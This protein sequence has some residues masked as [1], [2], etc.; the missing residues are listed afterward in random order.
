MGQYF[1]AIILNDIELNGKEIIKI[2]MD[3]WNYEYPAQL[4]DHAYI[5]NIFVNSF[6]YHL[7]KEGKFHKSRIV[8]AGEYANN[9]KGLNK[10]LYDLTNDDFSK[11]YYGP[12]L[13][14]PTHD[15][16]E[17]YYIINH[18]KKQYINKQKYK[19]LH[20]L[21]ILVAEG[22]DKSSS[23]YLGKNKKLAGFWARDIISIEKEI[24]NEFIEFIFDI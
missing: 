22:N 16:T 23:D 5:N 12:P 3:P 8:W 17:Y 21:P 11:Y 13:R 1:R 18:S 6:E 15:S 7:T 4:M 24:P 10:N 20:P 19:F 9:E 14:G 2:F